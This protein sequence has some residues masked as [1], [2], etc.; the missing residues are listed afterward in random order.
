[1][2]NKISILYE[3]D[4]TAQTSAAITEPNDSGGA[5]TTIDNTI[6][7]N[8]NGCH[9]YKCFVVVTVAPS[10][11]DAIARLKYAGINSGTPTE[12]DNGSIGVT[13]PDGETGTF[14][15][16]DIIT[17]AKFSQVKLA[18]EEYDFTASLVVTPMLP[19]VQ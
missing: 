10:G 11:G 15:I 3:S 4:I 17:P 8:G 19:E 12:F 13:I 5:L 7:Q 18:A 16:G 9:A 1:M 2:T 6:G 14:E